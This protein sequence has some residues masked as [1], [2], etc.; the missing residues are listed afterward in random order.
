[1]RTF[2]TP[3][4]LLLA[5]AAAGVSGCADAGAAE[6]PLAPDVPAAFLAEPPLQGTYL[7][8]FAGGVPAGF[9]ARVEALGGSVVFAHDGAG[10]GAVDGLSPAAAAELGALQG[11]S[12]V[13]AD[14]AT[15][16][17][18]VAVE[19]EAEAEAVDPAYDLASPENPRTA[20]IF[21][22]Q[23]N[24]DAILAPWAWATGRLGSPAV[25]VAILDS[26]LDYT[27]PDLQGRVDLASSRSFVPLQDPL[28]QQ[29]F[30]GAHPI[31][32]LHWH[33]TFVGSI[34]A[35]NAVIA[36]GVTSRVTLVGLKVCYISGACPVSAVLA[37]LVHAADMRVDVANLSLGNRFARPDSSASARPGP[38]LVAVV[39]Q[40]FAYANRQGV[41]VVVA[42]GNQNTDLDHDGNDYRLYCAAPGAVCVSGTGPTGG[43][44]FGPWVDADARAPYS[45][46]GRSVV[47][48]AAPGGNAQPTWSSC[49]RFS[50]LMPFCRTRPFIVGASGTSASAPH[51]TGTA[52]LI[53]EDVGR[54]PAQVRARLQ[55]TADD[56]GQP[57]TDPYYGKGRINVARAA[58][59]VG[60]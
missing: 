10:I 6:S 47:S 29:V 26:G 32:D 17:D 18:D 54:D 46:Y 52:A 43:G 40:A 4:L 58:G 3:R 11:V 7:V 5:L 30:P 59:V 36:A 37:A 14:E 9:A 15:L 41:T 34:V 27:H 48:V 23:W 20:A 1:M 57:G 24:L 13:A 55:Q 16:L 39:N 50:L 45:N 8:R 38:S 44:M 35:S 49:S 2:P 42:A 25:R 51:A 28:V 33:G 21:G 12:D 19:A 60:A 31:A 53:V 56:L 22:R